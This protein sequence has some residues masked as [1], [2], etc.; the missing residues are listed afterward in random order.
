MGDHPSP[1]PQATEE[2]N[3][4][5]IKP[6]LAWPVRLLLRPVAW[7]VFEQLAS[8]AQ[9]DPIGQ[10][11]ARAGC[12]GVA[13]GM[14]LSKDTVVRAMRELAG[15]GLVDVVTQGSTGEGH[16]GTSGYR[17]HPDAAGITISTRQPRMVNSD[18][19][20][21]TIEPARRLATTARDTPPSETSDTVAVATPRADQR[22]TA[23]S[24]A[25][26]R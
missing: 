13:E 8:I 14:G 16:F 10:W 9:P 26:A 25:V 6:A 15:A 5:T 2:L 18:A 1:E 20:I 24:A 23:V 19:A 22:A 7:V 21:T 12:R 4:V 3:F 11:M 17:L